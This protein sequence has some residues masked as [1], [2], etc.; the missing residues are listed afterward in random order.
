[1]QKEV[2]QTWCF[3]QPPQEVWEYLTQ[4]HLLKLWLGENDFKPVAGHTFRFV[5]PYGNDSLCEVLE[6]SPFTRIAF[7]WQKNSAED[8]RPFQS[9]VTWTLVPKDGGTE[10]QLFHGGFTFYKDQEA[11]S[12]GWTLCSQQL[13]VE[14]NK[15]TQ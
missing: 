7:T 13:E 3:D 6:I 9:T 11:H 2:R 10:L 1:M 8:N 12:K 4:P 5:S 14:L 15:V